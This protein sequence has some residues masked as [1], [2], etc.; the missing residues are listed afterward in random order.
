MTV[1]LKKRSVWQVLAGPPTQA[2]P[3]QFLNHGVT[4]I[5]TGNAGAWCPERP[6]KE[7]ESGIV[8]QFATELHVREVLCLRSCLSTTLAVRL[9]ASKFEYPPQL[10]GVNSWDIQHVQHGCCCAPPEPCDLGEPVLGASPARV[11][12]VQ[13]G[14]VVGYAHR[15][16]PSPPTD[17]REP[18]LPVEE[19]SL[20]AS[21]TQLRQVVAQ[22]QDLA[23]LHWGADASGETPMEDELV[24]H[25][26]VPF[27]RA[28]G[29]PV[30]EIA[31]K[32]H[33]IDV[34][35]FSELSRGPKSCNFVIVAMRL[36]MGVEVALSQAIRY[37]S[38][39]TFY[40]TW[41]L[42]TASATACM[43]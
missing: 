30:Q 43:K 18:T 6:D 29:R 22:V 16:I 41:L 13:S 11:S 28:L 27:L 10:D 21:L 36:G 9:V 19:M 31:V 1:E 14:D 4:L 37:A 42:R 33:R 38:P 5:G 7:F 39:L 12:G 17:W 23:A 40:V 20:N 26:V 15:F 8:R 25:D 2:C 35:V 34:R 3:D 24:A 32:W